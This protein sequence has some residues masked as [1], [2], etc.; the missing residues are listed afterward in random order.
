MKIKRTIMSIVLALMLCTTVVEGSATTTVASCKTASQF[1]KTM[2]KLY[3]KIKKG[4]NYK[5]V[6]KILKKKGMQIDDDEEYKTYEFEFSN[7]HKGWVSYF[8]I[9]IGF[10]E[11]KLDYKTYIFTP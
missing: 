7:K 1:A 4:M 9:F 2:R 10:D 5:Q 3:K 11:G 6:K 8:Q